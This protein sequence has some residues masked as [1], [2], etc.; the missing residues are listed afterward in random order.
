VED[1]VVAVGEQPFEDMVSEVLSSLGDPTR[2]AIY[3]ALRESGDAISV[4]DAG[5][6][7]NLHPNVA[8]YH[9]AQ[10]VEAGYLHVKRA[11]AG[12]S[13]GRPAHLFE[14]TDLEIHIDLPAESFKLLAG[15]LTRVLQ[16]VASVDAAELAFEVGLVQ[17]EELAVALDVPPDADLAAKTLVVTETMQGLGFGIDISLDGAECA[18]QTTHCPFGKVALESPRVVCALDQGLVAGLMRAM[19]ETVDVTV[20]PHARIGEPCNTVVTIAS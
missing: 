10:L 6:A 14:A 8:R 9:L 13:G 7:F 5:I 17:G 15:L 2:R 3:L 18:Y 20:A 19:N 4:A 1:S 11:A 16:R 12:S